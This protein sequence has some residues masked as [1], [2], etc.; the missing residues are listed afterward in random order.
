VLFG[1]HCSGGIK[2]ALD[3]AEAIGCDAVQL[4]A[5]SPRAWRFPDHDPADLKAFRD[6]LA[7]GPVTA[8]LVHGLYLMNLATPDDAIYEKSATTLCKTVGA[9]SAIGASVVFHV[10]SHLGAG[11]DEGLKRVVPAMKIALDQ[12]EGDTWLL[13]EN[14][15]GTGNTIG[16]SV[17]ELARIFDRLDGH[18]RLGVCLDS[19]HLFVSGVDV[20]DPDAW[21]AELDA[22]DKAIGLDRLRWLHVNDSV[23]PLGS[24][25]DRHANVGEGEIG[26]Q[27]GAFLSHPAVQGLP[28][29]LETAGRDGH[30]PG[31]EDIQDL[32]DLHARWVKPS[33]AMPKAKPTA[34]KRAKSSR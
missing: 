4:F 23:A 16:R 25:R 3:R 18:P 6:R 27:L 34:K 11:F 30:H 7:K 31:A 12:C 22:L 26:E 29:V 32:R 13:M 33:K 17:D 28:A 21:A 14:S 8:A 9:A 1:A 10:G 24:N 19:C 15:A 5:Q 20:R 2:A